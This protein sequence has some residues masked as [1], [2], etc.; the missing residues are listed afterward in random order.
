MEW[1][2]SLE[3]REKMNHVTDDQRLGRKLIVWK[4][5]NISNELVA[6]ALCLIPLLPR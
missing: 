1:K 5:A 4:I 2:L 3:V 6:R